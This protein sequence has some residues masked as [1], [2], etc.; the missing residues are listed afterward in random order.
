M[1]YGFKALTLTYHTAP[2]EVRERYALNETEAKQ[3]LHMLQEHGVQEAMVLS[4]CNRTEIY[5]SSNEPQEPLL[6]YALGM[7]KSYPIEQD[8]QYFLHITDSREAVRHLFEVGLGLD[9]QVLGDL[10]I[11]N[12]VKKAYQWA[13]DLQMAG[14][15]L[16]RLMHTIFFVNKKVVQ[17][18]AFRDGAASTSYAAVEIAEEI[19]TAIHEP[20]ILVVGVGEIGADV[21]RNLADRPMGEVIITN[22]TY[23]KAAALAEETGFRVEPFEKLDE[24][25]QKADIIISSVGMSQPLFNK[26]RIA[27]L[28]SVA[29]FKYFIDL[30]IPRSVAKEIEEIPGMVVYNVDDISRR[31]QASI[32][33]RKSAIPQV[34]ALME[35]GLAEF[36]DWSKEMEVSP[37]IKKL[38]N[39][40]EEIRRK[41]IA[42]YLKHLDEKEREAVERVTKSMI[43]KIIQ[44][45]VLQL[46][47]ACKRG[48]AE[49]LVDVLNDLFNLEKQPVQ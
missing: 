34:R 39:A 1:L 3:L 46:K 19:S 44:L 43:Q 30:A 33:A 25:L 20:V 8:K 41:E 36:E 22:R 29:S 47:A 6:F 23:E 24:W 45:P 31:V 5:Y 21:C 2:V 37:T 7:L 49:T 28:T 13:A 18:T 48:E 26:E 12:Q 38:K 35:E 15:F 17:Q 27:A 42:K 4:T 10:Q 9:S 32:E 14:P 40:L 11:I 16:H